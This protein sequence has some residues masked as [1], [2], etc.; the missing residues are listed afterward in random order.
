MGRYAKDAGGGDFAPAP[1]G[2]HI[3]RCI[4][5]IDLGTQHSEYQGKPTV[6]NQVFI[7]W[8]L[9]E[10]KMDDGKPYSDYKLKK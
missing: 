5:V 3:G 4:K 1:A 6:R 10:E 8:E 9:C 7:Q 2:N